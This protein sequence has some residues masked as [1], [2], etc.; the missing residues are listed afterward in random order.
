M[1]KYRGGR[2]NEEVKKELSYIIQNDVKDPRLTSM[3][4]VTY[5]DVTK[6]LKYAKVF[7]SLFGTEASKE[8]TMKALNSSLGFIRRELG[9]RVNLRITPEL[10]LKL[11]N[12][13]EKGMHIDSILDKIKEQEIHGNK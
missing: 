4:S 3:I 2:I 7:L 6:D 5:V 13:M 10:I 12:S 11:D 8:E 9:K 1:T